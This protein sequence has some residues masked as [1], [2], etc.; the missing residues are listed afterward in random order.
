MP[1]NC[2]IFQDDIARL[3]TTLEQARKGATLIGE[4]LAKKKLRSN[5]TKSKYV[6]LGQDEFKQRTRLEAQNNPVMIEGHIMEESMEEKYLGDMIHTDRLAASILSTVNKRLNV[7][8]SKLNVIM[9][10]AENPK[11][12]GLQNSQCAWT[13]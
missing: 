5:H 12:Y 3:N 10:L 2:L 13:L 6:L 9:N 7:L 1:L 11:M 4:T 8:F